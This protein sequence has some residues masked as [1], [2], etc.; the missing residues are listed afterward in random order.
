MKGQ[1]IIHNNSNLKNLVGLEG[2]VQAE[3][4]LQI[5]SNASLN[6]LEGL[7]S[8]T[9]IGDAL[10]IDNN[11]NLK[12]LLGL[13]NVE[14]IGRNLHITNNDALF[15]LVGLNN[16]LSINGLLQVYNNAELT[17][18]SG[19]DSINHNSILDLAILDSPALASCAVKSICDYLKA[20]TKLVAISQN[21]K[22][23]STKAEIIEKC[24]TESS[25]SR[26]LRERTNILFYPNP[27]FGRLEIK[28]NFSSA[29]ITIHDSMGKHV[30]K[31]EIEE[32]SF[33]ISELP[34]G[35]YMIE[36]SYN[37]KTAVERVVKL[38]K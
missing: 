34:S 1:F 31:K 10:V 19:I 30:L 24:P 17:S 18:L 23:C 9:G 29:F 15:N 14:S 22:C 16:L 21:S 20:D 36:L 27:T 8:L 5:S 28:E 3:N 13:R 33:D 7:E 35:V 38:R 37:D 6:G 4:A 11:P 12:S 26:P 25:G 2:I 32:A